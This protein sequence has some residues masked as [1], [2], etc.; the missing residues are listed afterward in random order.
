MNTVHQKAECL[1]EK[2]TKQ[3]FKSLE[4]F[5]QK[6][7][8]YQVLQSRTCLVLE[9]PSAASIVGAA[10]NSQVHRRRRRRTPNQGAAPEP[11]LTEKDWMDGDIGIFLTLFM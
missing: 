3:Y 6:E 2:P 8:P 1:W 11:V 4:L 10:A 9:C 7:H 5:I